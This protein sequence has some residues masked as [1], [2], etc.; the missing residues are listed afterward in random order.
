ML[1]SLSQS[2]DSLELDI[3]QSGLASDV[4]NITCSVE[5]SHMAGKEGEEGGGGSEGRRD[6][7]EE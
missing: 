6:G 7:E 3:A 4:T 5:V 1:I 2:H